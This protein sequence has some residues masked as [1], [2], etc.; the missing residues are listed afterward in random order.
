LW[1]LT[2][3]RPS[4][5]CWIK[6][7]SVEISDR[8]RFSGK[9][10]KTPLLWVNETL[11]TGGGHVRLWRNH[12]EYA[13]RGNPDRGRD[14]PRK[15]EP[16]NLNLL[17]GWLVVGH[18]MKHPFDFMGNSVRLICQPCADW[19]DVGCWLNASTLFLWPD[20]RKPDWPQYVVVVGSYRLGPGTWRQFQRCKGISTLQRH[21]FSGDNLNLLQQW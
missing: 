4:G 11:W 8:K 10:Y 12:E 18:E 17:C 19:A 20:N 6:T 21:C 1:T 16:E 13:Q 7:T 2:W 9:D 5:R 14:N 15:L 3:P